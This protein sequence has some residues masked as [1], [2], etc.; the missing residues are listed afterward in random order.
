[1]HATRQASHHATCL[2]KHTA[3][4]PVKSTKFLCFFTF[5]F[6]HFESIKLVSISK[7]DMCRST[8]LFNLM[9]NTLL[10]EKYHF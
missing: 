4:Q 3:D 9:E 7:V 10:G 6:E 2:Q 8:E 5:A 1:L